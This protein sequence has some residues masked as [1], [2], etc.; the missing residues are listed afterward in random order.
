MGDE[1]ETPKS[2]ARDSE[3]FAGMPLHPKL[4]AGIREL[5]YTTPTPIQAGTIPEAVGG[6]DLIGTAQTGTGKTAAFLLPILERLLDQQTGRTLALVLTPTR[7]LAIQAEGFLKQLGR[8]THLHGTAVY[9]GVGMDDQRRA[10]RGGS[11]IIIATPA[12]SWTT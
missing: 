9:G 1:K 2:G 6:R 3:G 10:L 5:G 12:G 4:K 8:H 11:E 7:E